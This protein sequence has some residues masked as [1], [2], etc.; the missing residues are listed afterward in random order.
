MQSLPQ[1]YTK[2]PISVVSEPN[3]TTIVFCRI[4]SEPALVTLK[5]ITQLI[6]NKNPFLITVESSRIAPI[7]DPAI[8]NGFRKVIQEIKY[9]EVHLDLFGKLFQF[10]ADVNMKVKGVEYSESLLHTVSTKEHVRVLLELGANV[11]ARNSI[12][13]SLLNHSIGGICT[14]GDYGLELLD[15]LLSY[16][17]DVNLPNCIGHTPLMKIA[18]QGPG[19]ASVSVL[20]KLIRAG[21]DIDS[22]TNKAGET[23]LEIAS[24][25]NPKLVDKLRNFPKQKLG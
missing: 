17:A 20:E 12:G 14:D 13:E 15:L 7:N 16:D 3:A 10:G 23:V 8:Q 1:T 25:S 21:A 11:D 4:S 24:K 19:Y 2:I 22:L 9:T 5:K 18:R 6:Q